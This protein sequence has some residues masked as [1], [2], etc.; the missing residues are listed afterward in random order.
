MSRPFGYKLSM[1]SFIRRGAEGHWLPAVSV[2]LLLTLAVC[3]SN[4]QEWPRFR[5][6]NGSGLG[7]A[8]IP[9]QWTD[10]NRKWTIKLPGGGHGSPVVWG[11]RLFVLCGNSSTGQRTAVCVNT[12][13]GKILWQQAFDEMVHKL[14]RFNSM[15]S[16]TPAVDAEQVY[17]AWG[18]PTKMTLIAFTHD[19]KQIWDANLGPV[20]REQGFGCSPILHDDLV[21]LS[22]DQEADCSLL[23]VDRKTGK[24]R[25]KLPR[26][27]NH[28]NY[29]TP[30]V[31]TPPGGQAQIVMSSWRLGL[32]GINPTSQ[33]VVWENDVYSKKT[34]ERAIGSPFTAGQ[35]VI[36][37]CG[38]VGGMK[39]T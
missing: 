28:S 10:A 6:P 8:D 7:K 4:A 9:A 19:G 27:E 3:P 13:D 18:T 26:G 30:C 36:A 38:F 34:A 22:N 16:S 24:V 17:F 29:A 31:Y 25:W 37:N 20:R 11:N 23:A 12:E 14:H 32:A 1:L 21:L 35:Y 2:A 5:G 39:H 15:A 33:K